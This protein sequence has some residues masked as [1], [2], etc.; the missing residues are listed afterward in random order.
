MQLRT[1]S[2]D[3]EAYT[4]ALLEL[5]AST[6]K[7]AM[8]CQ[9]LKLSNNHNDHERFQSSSENDDENETSEAI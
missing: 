1:K 4:H 5:N 6:I 2:S 8:Q 9:L 3:S 7:N